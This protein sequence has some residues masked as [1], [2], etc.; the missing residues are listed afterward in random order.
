MNVVFRVDAS[1]EMGT[2]HVMR[3][4]TLASELRRRGHQCHFICRD[5]KA[6]LGAQVKAR[7]FGLDLLK[8]EAQEIFKENSQRD[9]HA[10]WLS[11][12]WEYDA[13]QTK[14]RL[15]GFKPDWLIVDHYSLDVK[16]EREVAPFVGRIMVI[17]DLADRPHD[18]SLLLDQNLG[19][20]PQDYDM[21]VPG[22]TQRLIGPRYALLRPEF[23]QLRESSL[24]RRQ[25]PVLK[26][27]L[28]S[29]GGV[30]QNNVTS[31]V[32]SALSECELPDE[33]EI[34]IVMGATAPAL[35]DVRAQ[36]K[37]LRFKA[38][39]NVNVGNMA[40][41]MRNADLSIGAAGSTSWERCCL[42]LPTIMVILAENQRMIGESLAQIG[43]AS[44]VEENRVA[45]DLGDCIN[46][47][48]Q[49]V[50]VRKRL[51]EN[52]AAICDGNGTNRVAEKLEQMMIS[53]SKPL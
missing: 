11:V 44:L 3:C 19:R 27:I 51:I 52:S 2:G 43:A 28:V 8:S 13:E 23:S 41:R 14:A 29:L 10:H 18:C 16:W 42:G 24:V 22:S 7:G 53:L 49:S 9:A 17:D 34:D 5:A 26:R 46:Q 1:L 12:P 39:V 25:L 35:Q 50:D 47:L 45:F 4:M 48:A 6:H 33:T 20:K 36:S 38:T 40:E 32:L 30:D 31:K 37:E 21:L 15:N